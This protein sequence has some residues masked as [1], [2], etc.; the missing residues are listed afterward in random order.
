MPSSLRILPLLV[1]CLA[2][3][4]AP[5]AAEKA[6][7]TTPLFDF[8]QDGPLWASIDDT[9]MGG[10][11]SSRSY[12]QGGVAVF[13]GVLS[14]ENGGGFCSVRSAPRPRDLHGHRGLRLRVRGDGKVYKLRLRTDARFDGVS[15][16]NV[17][18]A[19]ELEEG[20]WV[21]IRLAFADFEPVYRGR[22]VRDA[23]R[24]DL[25]RI[26]TFG[27]LISDEQVGAFRLEIA[28]LEA[29]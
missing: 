20:E 16:Q 22:K 25:S 5:P 13:E 28:A 9:V 7:L 24:L 23:G 21:E 12:V 26:T 8:S 11:S 6:M 1:A 3:E 19:P 18:T 15:W 2:A 17:F 4:A 29:Y 14:L 10:R 27:L